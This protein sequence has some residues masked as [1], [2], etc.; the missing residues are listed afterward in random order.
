M[1]LGLVPARVGVGQASAVGLNQRWTHG[2]LG[3]FIELVSVFGRDWLLRTIRLSEKKHHMI[4]SGGYPSK[5]KDEQMKWSLWLSQVCEHWFLNSVSVTLF[6]LSGPNYRTQMCKVTW[7]IQF[8]SFAHTW[9]W[10]NNAASYSNHIVT[11]QQWQW[12]GKSLLCQ[13]EFSTGGC[14]WKVRKARRPMR[15]RGFH[16]QPCWTPGNRQQATSDWVS[17]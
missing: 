12:K 6:L 3:L 14:G 13:R 17:S 5:S 11:E 9:T 16:R 2:K 8:F 10:I 15:F 1:G 7:M 4:Q